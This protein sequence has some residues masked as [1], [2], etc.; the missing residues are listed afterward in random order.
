M[1]ELSPSPPSPPPAALFRLG[2][3]TS[4]PD[5]RSTI[6]DYFA[7]VISWMLIEGP[8]PDNIVPQRCRWLSTRS[9]QGAFPLEESVRGLLPT[10][11]PIDVT[12]RS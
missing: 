7:R 1:T 2:G 12:S 6:D 5:H 8:S 10:D 4:N 3:G 11:L 9:P